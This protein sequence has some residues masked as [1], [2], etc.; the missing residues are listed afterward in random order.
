MRRETLRLLVWATSRFGL[1]CFLL[2]DVLRGNAWTTPRSRPDRDR[3]ARW[4]MRWKPALNA[5][6][7]TFGDRFPAAETY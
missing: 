5:F 7:I 6:A 3:W 4:T 2:F 1:A